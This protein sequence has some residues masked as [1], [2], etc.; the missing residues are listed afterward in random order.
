MTNQHP[1]MTNKDMLILFA[2]LMVIWIAGAII[3]AL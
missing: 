2:K 1:Q 3:Q